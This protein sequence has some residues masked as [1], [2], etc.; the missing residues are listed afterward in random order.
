MQNMGNRMVT[1]TDLE[2]GL[3]YRR[4]YDQIHIKA[5]GTEQDGANLE[6]VDPDD[7]SEL[8]RFMPYMLKPSVVELSGTPIPVTSEE[9]PS[10]TMT[11]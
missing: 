7:Q 4:H 6:D 1:I 2:A 5:Q 3:V 8:Q 9:G 10:A 11:R